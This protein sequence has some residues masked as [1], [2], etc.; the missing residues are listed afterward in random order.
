VSLSALP[1]QRA[2]AFA[3]QLDLGLDGGICLACLSFVSHALERGDT[4]QIAA[5]LRH[6]TADMWDEGL[7]EL[8]LAAARGACE[9]GIPDAQAAL[10]D[11]ER[12]GGRS[13]VARAIVRRLAE[14]LSRRARADWLRLLA[15]ER[16]RLVPPEPN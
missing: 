10:A 4:R 6:V 1:P 13:P 8:A 9:N 3:S 2:T 14:E 5:E 15:G 7:K 11:L 12:N 16:V